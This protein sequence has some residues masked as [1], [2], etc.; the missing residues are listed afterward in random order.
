[1]KNYFKNDLLADA[2]VTRQIQTQTEVPGGDYDS[3]SVGLP[4]YYFIDFRMGIFLIILGII[5]GIIQFALM[6]S[7]FFLPFIKK[8][9]Y[10]CIKCKS[11]FQQFKAIKICPYCKGQVIPE[12]EYIKN[13]NIYDKLFTNKEY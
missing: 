1:M 6:G 12:K 13:Q 3:I 9:N 2:V 10:R 4:F 11:A 5:A 8:R 7:L